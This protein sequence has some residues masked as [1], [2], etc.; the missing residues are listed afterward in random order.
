ML[1]HE[2]CKNEPMILADILRI[3]FGEGDSC[4]LPTQ[5]K[6]LYEIDISSS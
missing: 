6:Q 2:F 3:M 1:K 5:E 4:C